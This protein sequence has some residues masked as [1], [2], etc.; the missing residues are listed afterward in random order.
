[1]NLNTFRVFLTV[2]EQRSMTQAAT[3]LHLTQS[4]ISQHIRGLEEELGF[5]LF[6]R[7]GKKLFP[8]AKAAELYSRG[9]KGVSEI[10]AALKDIQRKEESPRGAV[11]LGMPVEFGNNVVIPELSKMGA[12]YPDVDF[13]ITLDF[14][15]T[16]SGMVLRG[17]LDFA[18][19]DRFDV[20]P[21]LK[22]E[23]VASETL[24]LCGLKSY[25]KKFGPV[26][27]TTGYFSQLNYV[28]YK[29][30]EPVVRSWF[31]H[32]LHRHN[33]NIRTRAHI[34][35]VQGISKFIQSGLGVGILPDYVVSKLLA[36]GIDLY[37]FEGKRAPLK[38]DMSLIYLPL[39]DRALAQKTVME[40]LRGLPK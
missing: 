36:D 28:D 16:L 11:R 12:K 22:A 18:L 37:V 38:N 20:D 33:I 32:H 31:R 15:T 5:E 23:T 19:I 2:Y 29:T 26:K 40:C 34:F 10:E 25:V 35:D 9:K 1:M 6:E 14:A 30:G 21:S 7:V 3:Q 27:Y 17:E 8:T 13:A 4:G 39:K 24:L